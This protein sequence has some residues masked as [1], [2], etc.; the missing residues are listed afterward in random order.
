[1]TKSVHSQKSGF[2]A[3]TLIS[4]KRSPVAGEVVAEASLEGRKVGRE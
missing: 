3:R 1:M 2:Q 4:E